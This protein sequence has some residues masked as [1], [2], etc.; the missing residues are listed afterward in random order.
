ME[1]LEVL[2]KSHADEASGNQGEIKIV[3]RE[4]DTMLEEEELKWRQTAKQN[5]Y[6]LGDRDTKVFHACTS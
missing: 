1:K 3:Q 4:I 6:K 5:R 2:R